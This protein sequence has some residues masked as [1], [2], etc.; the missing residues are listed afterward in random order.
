MLPA[1][2]LIAVLAT[3]SPGRTDCTATAA[4][5]RRSTATCAR[6]A[7]AKALLILDVQPGRAGF[8][9]R[10]P[11]LLRWLREPDVALALDPEWRVGPRRGPGPRHRLD[12]RAEINAVSAWLARLVRARD[13]CRRS[14]CS[15]TSS[16]TR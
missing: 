3:A 1:L 2:E 15:S 12:R 6:R 10:G 13:A 11:P 14:C 4:A 7:P 8:L 5:P 9:D 16:P